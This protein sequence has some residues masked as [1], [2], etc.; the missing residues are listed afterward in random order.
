MVTE[1]FKTVPKPGLTVT[2][3]SICKVWH[4]TMFFLPYGSDNPVKDMRVTRK[5]LIFSNHA[6]CARHCT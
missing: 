6:L 4:Y 3:T 2:I 5:S 1:A